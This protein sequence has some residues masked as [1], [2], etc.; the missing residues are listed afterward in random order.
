[1]NEEGSSPL[2]EK[3]SSGF[4]YSVNWVGVVAG[5]LMLLIPFMGAWWKVVVGSGAMKIAIS[6]FHYDIVLAGQSLSSSLVSYFI[7]AAKLSVLIGGVFM[8]VGSFTPTKWWGRKLVDWGSKKVLWML[9]LLIA[10]VLLGTIFTNKFLSSLLSNII[11]GDVALTFSLPYLIGSGSATISAQETV[12]VNA[13]VTMEFTSSFW[14]AVATAVTGY[15]AKIYHGKLLDRL[16]V[17]G[18]DDKMEEEE[19]SR[20]ENED[21]NEVKEKT[22]REEDSG[23]EETESE[24]EKFS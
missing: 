11:E 1:M 15:G 18:K 4:I 9:V 13:P 19:K 21:G 3:E 20:G 10:F 16:G 14:L 2:K 7:L 6:P 22:G 24:E 12:K 23:L 5:V 17:L 8:I